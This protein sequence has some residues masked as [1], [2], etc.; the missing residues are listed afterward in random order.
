MKGYAKFLNIIRAIGFWVLVIA[1]VAVCAATAVIAIR[2][3]LIPTDLPGA[4]A[5]TLNGSPVDLHTFAAYRT[6]A[7]IVLGILILQLILDLVIL[8]RI[9]VALREVIEETPF[10]QR[11]SRAL[12]TS[13]LLV[14]FYGLLAIGLR[15]Y[16][17]FAFSA[18]S[19]SG[20]VAHITADLSFI[21]VAVFLKMLAGISEFGR[22]EQ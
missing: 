20:S 15:V 7:L 2:P 9:G 11:C 16:S 14:V 21:L 5:I 17:Y 12:N 18:L 3:D 1:L 4:S 22:R 19:P 8:S 10:S 6:P 13:A